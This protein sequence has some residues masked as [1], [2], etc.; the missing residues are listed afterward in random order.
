MICLCVFLVG[1]QP[2]DSKPK[3]GGKPAA[4]PVPAV[5]PAQSGVAPVMRIDGNGSVSSSEWKGSPTVVYVM[6]AWTDQAAANGQVVAGLQTMAGL[7]VVPVLVD[8]RS[9]G[10]AAGVV[11]PALAKAGGVWAT[12]ELLSSLGGIRALPSAVLLDREGR[13]AGVWPGY[14]KAEELRKEIASRL[15]PAPTT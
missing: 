9:P 7:R 14:I 2:P 1:C 4:V 10:E 15:P 6:A 8:Q 13:V 5:V 12:P 3:P 11:D